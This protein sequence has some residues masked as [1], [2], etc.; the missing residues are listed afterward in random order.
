M[1]HT[2]NGAFLAQRIRCNLSV[3][4]WRDFFEPLNETLLTPETLQLMIQINERRF[5]GVLQC[6]NRE[7]INTAGNAYKKFEYSFEMSSGAIH[8]FCAFSEM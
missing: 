6:R 2:R 4:Y 3:S 7:L 1:M 5:K 8:Y